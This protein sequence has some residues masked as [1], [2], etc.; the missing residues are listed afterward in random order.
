M[1]N[2]FL[3]TLN[4]ILSHKDTVLIIFQTVRGYGG[5]G[6]ARVGHGWGTGGARV[7]H[8][9]GTGGARVG[10]GWGTGGSTRVRRAAVTLSNNY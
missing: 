4:P 8:G 6:G 2:V 5:T 10:H 9:W 3:S 1:A 7:G